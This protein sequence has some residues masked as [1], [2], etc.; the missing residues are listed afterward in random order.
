MTTWNVMVPVVD[1]IE[2]GSRSQ[3]IADLTTRLRK[4]GFRDQLDYAAT[5]SDAFESDVE[6][7]PRAPREE[8]GE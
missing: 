1:L 5:E 7:E 3:A 8:T 6:A 4:A 2:A